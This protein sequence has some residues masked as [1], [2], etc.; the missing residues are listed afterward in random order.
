[1]TQKI[2]LS[3]VTGRIGSAAAR[4]LV[5]NGNT[6]LRVIVRN[7]DVE[8]PEELQAAE[9]VQADFGD[10][11]SIQSAMQ[12]VSS[13]LLVAPN[14]EQ[15]FELER[16]FIDAANAAGVSHVVKISS[17]EAGPD[18][19]APIPKLHYKAEQ[20]LRASGMGWTFLRPNFFLQ[21]FLMYA[22]SIKA[23]QLFALPF[24]DTA[25][26]PVDTADVGAV[27]AAVLGAEDHAGKIYNLTATELT[28]LAEI[29]ETFSQVC[30]Q[31]VR[32]VDQDP[33]EFRAFMLKIVPNPWLASAVSDLFD[34]IRAGSLAETSTD[35]HDILGRNPATVRSFVECYRAAF[36]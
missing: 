2:L 30:D 26:A 20:H 34:E 28:T 16:N 17:M 23:Q 13:A 24:G 4:V 3:G 32:Y 1:M 29:A 6:D 8:L 36:C 7:P 33:A 19:Q 10:A 5:Q 15:Q 27:A 9:R 22:Q 35:I 31:P 14:G 25:M 21:N 18:A 12:N 11:A